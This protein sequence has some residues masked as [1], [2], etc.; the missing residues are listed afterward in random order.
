MDQ[1]TT[2]H[3]NKERIKHPSKANSNDT[4][5]GR[6]FKLVWLRKDYSRDKRADFEG[7]LPCS[8]Y[9]R[10]IASVFGFDA[11]YLGHVSIVLRLSLSS[12]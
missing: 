5:Q 1:M 6:P 7:I 9:G 11:L 4:D 8:L 3:A 10:E 2:L 12:G